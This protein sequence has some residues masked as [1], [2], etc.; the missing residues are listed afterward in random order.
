MR[1]KSPLEFPNG[2]PCLKIQQAERLEDDQLSVLI[3][4]GMPPE[5]HVRLT[6]KGEFFDTDFADCTLDIDSVALRQLA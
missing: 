4:L 1:I 6:I 5:G 2:H 3:A